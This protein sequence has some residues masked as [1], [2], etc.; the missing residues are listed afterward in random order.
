MY[1]H[2]HCRGRT[3]YSD[4]LQVCR[5]VLPIWPML[6]AGVLLIVFGILVVTDLMTAYKGLLV[7]GFV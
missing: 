6:V 2:S 5:D 4:P 3:C 7:G 1:G